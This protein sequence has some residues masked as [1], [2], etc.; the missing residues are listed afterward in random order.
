MPY[1]DHNATTP[2]SP[3]AEAAWREASR[4]HWHNPSSPY[5]S[6]ARA[7]A[8]L[9]QAREELAASLNCAPQ[10]IV[11]TS[12]AT[13][14]NNAVLRWA[15]GRSGEVCLGATEHPSLWEAAELLLGGRRQVLPVDGQGR[16]DLEA[17]S[18]ALARRPALVSVMAANNETGVCQ[19][20]A[21]V[22]RLCR[23]AGVPY[24]CD[25]VQWLGK[26]PP[27][28]LATCDLITGSA[29]KFGGPKGVGFLLVGEAARSLRV[30][31]GGG[32][33]G[34]HRAGT[35]NLPGVLALVAALRERLEVPRRADRESWRETFIATLSE[36]LGVRSVAAGAPRL[37]NTV[38]LIMPAFESSRWIARLDKQGFQVSS[39]SAC[40]TGREGPSHVLSAHG[41][42][43][44]EARRALRF[45]SGPETT[46]EDWQALAQAVLRVWDELRADESGPHVIEV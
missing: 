39:G 41:F 40:A 33:E 28:G 36:E 2:L 23:A 22:A 15:A 31:L 29:H 37:W 13:E 9:E 10:A 1:F 42:S 34:D 4:E 46:A 5:R 44:E 18:R 26:L 21:E 43:A 24:H 38:M 27:E 35:E 12:G 16:V 11:F 6:A 25:A 8:A 30:Q 14:A 19:P 20:W 17:L 3:A 7:R 32:Q 45:S